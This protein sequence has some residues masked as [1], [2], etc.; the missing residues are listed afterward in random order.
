[1]KTKHFITELLS[2]MAPGFFILIL[3]TY[4]AGTFLPSPYNA[5]T[6]A[7]ILAIGGLIIYFRDQIDARR[8]AWRSNRSSQMPSHGVP[9]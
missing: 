9:H 3:P 4:L 8:A 5:M 7:V 6:C 2:A 1:M